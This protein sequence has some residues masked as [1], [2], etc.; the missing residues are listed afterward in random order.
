[1]EA[2]TRLTPI[3]CLLSFVR[4]LDSD[5]D[6]ELTAAEFNQGM[7]KLFAKWNTDKSGSLSEEQLRIGLDQDFAPRGFPR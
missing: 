5:N 7:E 1:M 6:K 3:Q 2:F 4:N